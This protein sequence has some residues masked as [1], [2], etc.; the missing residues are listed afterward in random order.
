MRRTESKQIARLL[1]PYDLLA[2]SHGAG[3]GICASVVS[4]ST[5]TICPCWS[6]VMSFEW[7]LTFSS[8]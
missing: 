1:I 8:A 3:R 5:L 2:G 6:K 4:S 7:P